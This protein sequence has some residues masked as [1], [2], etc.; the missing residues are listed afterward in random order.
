LQCGQTFTWRNIA[1]KRHCEKI[2]FERWV[3][4][5]YSQRQLA[6][7]S[8]W[9]QDKIKRIKSYWLSQKPTL[10]DLVFSVYDCL[11]FD[12]T[13]FAH[14]SCLM[15]FW[16]PHTHQVVSSCF[17]PKENYFTCL[18]WFKDLKARGLCPQA[19]TLDG[20][21]QIIKAIREVWPD[22]LLQRCLY[23][24]QRQGQ[25]WLRQYPK[26]NL[27]RELKQI[28]HLLPMLKTHTL[29]RVWWE[30][31]CQWQS[32]FKSDLKLLDYQNKVD[33]D[34][35][36]AYRLI[37]YAYQNMFHYLDNPR[38]PATSNGLESYFS[39][40]KDL[41]RR[42]RG[43]RKTHLENYLWWYVVLTERRK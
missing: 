4:E 7:Q 16:D 40:L 12:G 18:A 3:K 43:L 6:A 27:A 8:H 5:G 29:K 1:V 32:R 19:I 10:P 39:Q 37:E 30:K 42:H 28:L 13:Y 21:T 33:S 35:I 20:Q 24:I 36:R 17:A 14:Q 9:S 22:C 34:I 26:T 25:M 38:I 15:L 41:Y 11:V 23:H 2:W 31:Y